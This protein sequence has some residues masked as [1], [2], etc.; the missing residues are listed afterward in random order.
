[1]YQ[2][3]KFFFLLYLENN[4]ENNVQPVCHFEYEHEALRPI[5][6]CITGP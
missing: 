4:G 1:M 6:K 3:S 5:T 2:F